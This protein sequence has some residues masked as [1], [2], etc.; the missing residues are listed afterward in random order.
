MAAINFKN[1][2]MNSKLEK[3]VGGQM[4]DWVW[5]MHIIIKTH[6]KLH[7]HKKETFKKTDVGV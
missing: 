5:A 2:D 1:R 7:D 4:E 6:G 3:K